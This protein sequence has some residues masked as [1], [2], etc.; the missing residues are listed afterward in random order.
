MPSY[1]RSFAS[2]EKAKYW[3]KKNGDVKPENVFKSSHKEYWFDCDKCKHSFDKALNS[4]VRGNWCPYCAGKKMCEPQDCEF[5]FN[6]SFASHDKAKFWS[7]KNGSVKPRAVF[8]SSHTK[9]WFDCDICNHSFY[10]ALNNIVALSWCSYCCVPSKQLCEKEECSHCLTRSFASHEKAKCWS[11]KNWGVNPRN[12]FKGSKQIYCFDCTKCDHSFD[13]ALNNIVYGAWCPYCSH[14]KLC[15]TQECEVCFNNS[16]ASHEK[17]KF[18][19]KKNG[20]VKPRDVFKQCNTKFWFDCD[21]CRCNDGFDSILCNIVSGSWCPYCKNKT[22]LKLYDALQLIYPSI[23]CQFRQE[24]CKKQKHLPFD[25]CIPELK[26][27]IELDGAQHFIQVSNWLSPEETHE[28]DSFKEK[29][30]ND[31]GYSIIRIIQEDVFNDTYDWL[32]KLVSS[33]EGIRNS[34]NIKNHYLCENNEY[35]KF[36]VADN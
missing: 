36:I 21:K 28:N 12:V 35:D 30:A 34:G 9:Y 7:E 3:S 17:A 2:H 14:Q 25:F 1:E 15:K 22:E 8:K 29:C 23:I 5:C 26:I 11:I 27:I 4:V 32:A 33:I 10:S 13:S 20:D 18:W 24:W 31:N 19:S 6:T 16:F